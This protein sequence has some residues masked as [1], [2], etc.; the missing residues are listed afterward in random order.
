MAMF[1]AP[2]ATATLGSLDEFQRA[3]WAVAAIA[4]ACLPLA[5]W[6]PRPSPQQGAREGSRAPCS[7]TAISS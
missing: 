6:T 7:M 1:M 2:L 3:L 4:A 5:A